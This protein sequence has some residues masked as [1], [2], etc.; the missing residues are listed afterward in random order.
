MASV[1]KSVA[2][3]GSEIDRTAARADDIA[4]DRA[5]RDIDDVAER[6]QVD[7]ARDGAAGLIDGDRGCCLQTRVDGGGR[8][9]RPSL[10]TGP[11]KFGAFKIRM[12]NL[13]P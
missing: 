7:R 3:A 11:A 10:K 5:A 6:R 9:K 1:S 12:P 4:V 8:V 13:P 2:N